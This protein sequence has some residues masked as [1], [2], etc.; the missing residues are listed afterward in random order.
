[1]SGRYRRFGEWAAEA[2]LQAAKEARLAAEAEAAAKA[3]EE[4]RLAAEAAAAAAAAAPEPGAGAPGERG[5][6]EGKR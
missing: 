2:R 6:T 4:A 5:G 1:M 3:A